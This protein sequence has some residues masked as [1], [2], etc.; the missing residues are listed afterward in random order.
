MTLQT[1]GERD[2][3]LFAGKVPV[4]ENHLCVFDGAVYSQDLPLLQHTAGHRHIHLH[5]LRN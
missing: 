2:W 5:H 1:D 3:Y 4:E